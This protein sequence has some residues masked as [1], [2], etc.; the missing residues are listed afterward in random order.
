MRNERNFYCRGF[1]LIE[2]LVVV[3]IIGILMSLSFVGFSQAR[4]MGRDSKRKADL[5]QIRSAIELYRSDVGS[6][7]PNDSIPADCGS[8]SLIYQTT[9]TY[10]A[11][12]PTDP[13][14]PNQYY[15]YNLIDANHYCLC[16]FTETFSSGDT[17]CCGGSCGNGITC[18][19]AVKNP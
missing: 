11:T 1:T 13:A 6:Y 15:R 14:C 7:P 17:S 5:E 3:A 19:Y 9:D 16:A 10:M 12:I 8:H 4:K 2:L 18:N